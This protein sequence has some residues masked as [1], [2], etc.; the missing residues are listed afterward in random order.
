MKALANIVFQ[1]PAGA[2]SFEDGFEVMVAPT[3]TEHGVGREGVAEP[4]QLERI[5]G[6][7]DRSSGY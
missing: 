5:H 6:R 4:A 1:W 3:T 2:G 7:S